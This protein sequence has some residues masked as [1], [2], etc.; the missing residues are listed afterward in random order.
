M[1]LSFCGERFVLDLFHS[2][3]VVYLRMPFI[4]EM[5]WSRLGLFWD[6]PRKQPTIKPNIP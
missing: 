1:L 4:G 6:R 3:D 5:A 2:G